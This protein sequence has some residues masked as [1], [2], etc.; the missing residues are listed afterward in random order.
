[1]DLDDRSGV[2]TLRDEMWLEHPRPELAVRGKG[3]TGL[4]V[5]G[6]TAW[7]CFSNL[8]A[9]VDLDRMQIV[10]TIIDDAFNDLHQLTAW[11]DKLIVA[12]T[13][14]ESID[15]IALKDRSIRRVDLL[16]TD[17]RSDRPKW[18]QLSDT[19]PHLHHVSGASI[20][21]RD[22]MVV[23]LGR[24]GRLLNASTWSWIGPRMGALVHD[25][26]CSVDGSVWCTAVSGIVYRIGPDATVQS[27]SVA[28][29]QGQL[30]WTRGLAITIH[31]LLI[32][33]TAIRE[34]NRDYF[35]A[36]IGVE[37][38]D[39][40]ACV[41]AVSLCGKEPSTIALPGAATA[42]VFTLCSMSV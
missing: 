22:E 11:G 14:N 28:D 3:I 33:T 10:D 19:E 36:Q 5:R 39:V 18:N 4:C 20:N 2:L 8:I 38:P 15:I 24:Q 42:K 16:G 1:M 7:I 6:N 27:W 23:A 40:G 41:T 35:H 17:L 9:L 31:A 21:S 32:G 26:H 13:G 37:S 29:Y 34:T 25:V 12:N 30:G